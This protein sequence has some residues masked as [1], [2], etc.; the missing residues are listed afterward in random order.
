MWYLH[1]D[2]SGDLGFDFVN[3][4]PSKFF[5]VCILAISQRDSSFKIGQ[6]VKKTL[7]RKLNKPK[8]CQVY[9]LKGSSSTLE[10]K[11]YF[12]NQIKDCKL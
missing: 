6:A 8:K 12:W 10:V 7:R 2:E 11:Q 9:E 5:T 4:K 3:K 1:L